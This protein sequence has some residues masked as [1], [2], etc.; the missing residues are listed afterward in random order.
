MADAAGSR[1][2]AEV[3]VVFGAFGLLAIGAFV[4]LLLQIGVPDGPPLGARAYGVTGG[5]ALSRVRRMLTP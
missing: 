5:L 1:R 2:S 4:S 3:W